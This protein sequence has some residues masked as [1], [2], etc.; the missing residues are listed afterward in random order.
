MV[1]AKGSLHSLPIQKLETRN[2]SEVKIRQDF[3]IR[4]GTANKKH[5]NCSSNPCLPPE[6]LVL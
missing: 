6:V 3:E 4:A 5:L 2:R 1:A